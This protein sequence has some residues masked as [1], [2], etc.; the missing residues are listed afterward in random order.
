[1]EDLRRALEAL[2]SHEST[3][4]AAAE[5]Y[6]EAFSRTQDAWSACFALLAPTEEEG[7]RV[8]A[9]RT[10]HQLVRASVFKTEK[11]Q[12]SHAVVTTSEVESL[13]SALASAALSSSCG[14]LQVQVTL[15]LAALLLKSERAADSLLRDAAA[16]LHAQSGDATAFLLFLRMLPE[17]LHAKQLSLHPAR[18]AACQSAFVAAAE[19]T[20]LF[21]SQ[22]AE[23]SSD[24]RVHALS[25]EALASWADMGAA[26]AALAACPLTALAF[27]IS[28]ASP[29][30]LLQPS[31]SAATAAASAMLASCTPDVAAS[32][33]LCI[34]S[35]AKTAC[36][37]HCGENEAAAASMGATLHV[38]AHCAREALAACFATHSPSPASVVA[39]CLSCLCDA[40]DSDAIASDGVAEIL[41]VWDVA[42][43]LLHA[44]TPPRLPECLAPLLFAACSR[45]ASRA[46]TLCVLPSSA[47]G[48]LDTCVVEAAT[49]NREAIADALRDAVDVCGVASL[50]PH[51]CHA[52]MSASAHADAPLVGD[53]S[54]TA[55]AVEEGAVF[56]AAVVVRLA[57][58]R[59]ATG[60]NDV[61][62][63]SLSSCASRMMARANA[64]ASPQ[65]ASTAAVLLA[66]LAPWM[67]A[68]P[69]RASNAVTVRRQVAGTLATAS[70]SRAPAV[71]R[72][73]C[74]ALLR[75]T[76][77][78]CGPW[79]AA[80]G[81]LDSDDRAG[82]SDAAEA[83][84]IAAQDDAQEGLR[85]GQEPRRTLLLRARSAAL[86]QSATAGAAGDSDA[87]CFALMRL[88]EAPT[89]RLRAACESP[90][91]AHAASTAAT[92]VHDLGILVSSST[93]ADSCGVVA[94]AR[95][96]S[97]VLPPL[98]VAC[99]C[100]PLACSPLAAAELAVALTAVLAA[101]A[102]MTR[103][104]ASGVDA[105][106]LKCNAL[107]AAVAAF[108]TGRQ[109]MLLQTLRTAVE[110]EVG[111]HFTAGSAA[112]AAAAAFSS[113]PTPE[114]AA[115][116]TRLLAS[117]VSS[118]SAAL[119]APSGSSP[120]LLD[121]VHFSIASLRAPTASLEQARAAT[122]L[123]SVVICSPFPPAK[124][125][126]SEALPLDDAGLHAVAFRDA[127]SSMLLQPT[128][129]SSV[130]AALLDAAA[131]LLPPS[132]IS[133]VA[134]ALHAA[135]LAAGDE[136]MRAWLLAGVTDWARPSPLPHLTLTQDVA[137]VD[138]LLD[139]VN[140]SDPRRFKR[141]L[142]TRCGG[143]KKGVIA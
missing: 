85:P 136:Q 52:V 46:C 17:E 57:T 19:A 116:L 70:R 113:S 27:Q 60:D 62:F 31:V 132:C 107:A 131:G 105:E 65:A 24:V 81:A 141:C 104:A 44:A 134:D 95:V 139:I 68:L 8:W 54:I 79:L 106:R 77:S 37:P 32:L 28:S 43:Q 53:S 67:A 108:A 123:A 135:W 87:L 33:V 18:R 1:M 76:E 23:V 2:Y 119:I 47:H 142:K 15:A 111:P 59:A 3:S 93:R 39:V 56:A 83:H 140:R 25:L 13:L 55:A 49:S 50:L 137:F 82:S 72:A 73:A 138:S 78:G 86:V 22:S 38:V 92:A 118:R 99:R 42:R 20:L 66:A 69:S 75:L 29:A 101:A 40:L 97:F 129:A 48:H 21:V 94:C 5:A 45:L 112:L 120:P 91:V 133:D 98:D 80:E 71:A 30:E 126:P 90:A 64:A 9:A 51:L 88:A 103:H 35:L 14:P 10:L 41:T 11:R 117:C 63:A 6:L 100:L 61:I 124:A 84:R 143:K 110:A 58:T 125:A 122:E 115:P 89:V 26:A 4:R 128:V 96:A 74:L 12:A 16:A 34:S 114:S 102:A 7:H 36:A 121:V 130:V 127:A 109:P